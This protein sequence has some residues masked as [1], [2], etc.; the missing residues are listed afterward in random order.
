MKQIYLSIRIS[1]FIALMSSSQNSL[2]QCSTNYNQNGTNVVTDVPYLWGQGF[3]AECDGFLEYVQFISNSTGTVS[4]GTLN[5][6]NGNTVTGTPLYTQTYPSIIITQASDPIRVDVTGSL[7]LVQGNQY[8]FEFTVDNVDILADFANGYPDG[9][10]FQDGSEVSSVDF[11]FGISI[12]NT[13]SIDDNYEFDKEISLFP[14]PSSNF[15]IISNLEKI[16]SYLI[17][18]QIGQKVK[19]GIISNNQQIDI[20]NLTNGLYFLKFNNGNTLKF[21]KE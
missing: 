20:R 6:Y 19:K 8:T 7:S 13:L 12:T 1:L 4:A 17:V 2:A 5:I 10:A 9:S 14:N 18:N 15:I 21:I 3:I 11:I 16:E